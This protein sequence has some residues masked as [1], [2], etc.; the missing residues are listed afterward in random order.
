MK[1]HG[2]MRWVRRS[3][4]ELKVVIAVRKGCFALLKMMSERMTFYFFVW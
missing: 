3:L 1:S 4:R 2:S